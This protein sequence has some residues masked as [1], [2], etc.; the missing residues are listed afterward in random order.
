ME[1]PK[2]SNE[3]SE[4]DKVC[5]HCKRVLLLECPICHKMTRSL[6][7]EECGFVVVSKCQSC[8]QINKTINGSCKKC[9]F[10]TYKSISM[11]EAETDEFA[12]LVVTFPG[13]E[14]LRPVL[15]N[16]QLYN[17]FYN[18]IKEFLFGYG[19][20]ED[21]RVQLIEGAFIFKFYK[22]FSLSSSANKALKS[23]I[24]M[25]NKIANIAYKF[26]KNKK[27][28]FSCKMTILKRTFENDNDPFNTGL[29]VKMINTEINKDDHTVGLEIITDQYI[30]V[31]LSRQ[32]K[33]QMLYSSQVNDELLEFYGFPIKEYLTPIIDEDVSDDNANLLIKSKD[34]P[35]L[36]EMFEEDVQFD[37]YSN[38]PI[39]IRSESEF[40]KVQGADVP[41]KIQELLLEN[42]FIVLKSNQRLMLPSIDI[43]NA[44]KAVNSN[45]LH[46]VC[47][48]GFVYDPFACFKEL[49]AFSLGFDTKLANLDTTARKKLNLFD[50]DDYIYNLLV[51]KS[52]EEIDPQKVLEQYIEIFYKFLESQK[53]S[54]IFIENFDLIDETSL[55]ILISLVHTF[56]E[57]KIS[58]VVTVSEPYS[59]L[60]ASSDFLGLKTYKEVLIEKSDIDKIIDTI[61]YDITEIKD[62]FY[63][64]KISDQYL[65]SVLYFRH[66]FQYLIDSNIFVES[67]GKLILNAEKTILLP[68]SLEQ[69]LVKRF[70]GF[71][72]AECYVLA[73][74]SFLGHN[75]VLGILNDLEIENMEEV[76]KSL[77]NKKIITCH[78]FIVE[79]HNYTF[80]QKCI[81]DFLSDDVKKILLDNIF[82]KLHTRTMEVVKSLGL[83][84]ESQLKLSEI[85]EYAINHG[86]FNAYLRNCKRFFSVLKSIPAKDVLPE[87]SDIKQK[88]YSTLSLYLNKYPANKIYSIS[89]IIFEDSVRKKNDLNIIK[90]SSLMLDSALMDDNNTLALQSLQQ[91][92]TRILN[93]AYAQQQSNVLYQSFFYSCINIKV[94]FNAGKLLQSVES[95]KKI[96]ATI[97][98][99][100]FMEFG[101]NDVSKDEFI[102]YFM[103]ILF[104][105]ISAQVFTF[106]SSIE[107]FFDN[108]YYMFSVDVP[109]KNAIMQLINLIQNVDFVYNEADYG[110]DHNSQ[111]ISKFIKAF[112]LFD[113]DYNTFAQNIHEVKVYAK[114]FKYSFWNLLSD[115]I[116]GYCYQQ[117]ES[118]LKAEHIF[119]EVQVLSQKLG[120]GYL[121]VAANWFIANLKY[122]KEDYSSASKIINNNLALISKTIVGEQIIT[123]LS[124]MTQVNIIVK[125]SRYDTDIQPILYKINYA[126]EKYKLEH[127]KQFL[128]GTDEYVEEYNK[129]LESKLSENSGEPLL[130]QS[131]KEQELQDVNQ[132]EQA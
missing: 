110:D 93:P 130:E 27:T 52:F 118:Y 58:F 117:L 126:C 86:D 42:A 127:F 33:L 56:E 15:K 21:N 55:E 124:L 76:I 73:Y 60:N 30:N 16:K 80:L 101:A 25:M 111:L 83:F 105:G 17:K 32:Y 96:L 26:R 90:V 9:G 128:V 23:A 1:C 28:K 106:N 81:R 69:L 120:M 88:M 39:D 8:G 109:Y 40:L 4:R 131:N 75:M 41:R 34:L 129:I 104:Y 37:L 53:N 57:L 132:V 49:V 79:V 11:N 36:E 20:K 68:T 45:F 122:T 7:C 95:Q 63:F 100:L 74:A 44:I 3:V 50:K 10:S 64:N 5:P 89:K 71:S 51:H 102:S 65:G 14:G 113:G 77:I 19:R 91:I 99:E 22:E 29:N 31:L 38:K 108:I 84:T 72:E 107:R 78:N 125:Q 67:E 48:D 87:V 98:Q 123:L 94:L 47:S 103:D 6:L 92:L 46:V 121:L 97:N 70:E 116:I 119:N 61:P 115:L 54:V 18:K 85:A 35:T 66:A 82:N 43:I 13:I 62:S 24:E 112:K 114:T 2:C 12:C 59:I